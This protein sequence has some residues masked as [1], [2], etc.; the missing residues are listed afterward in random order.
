MKNIAIIAILAF[1]ALLVGFSFLSEKPEGTQIKQ[2]SSYNELQNFIKTNLET[3]SYFGGV[4]ATRSAIAE[5][6][7]AAQAPGAKSEDYSTTNI[8]VAGVDEAD[9]VKND[10]K[11]IYVVSGNSV[12]IL[13]AYPAEGAKIISTIDLNSAPSEIFVNGDKL[14]IFSQDYNYYIQPAVGMAEIA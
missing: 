1:I 12:V 14:V 8:Q 13:D 10:G 2:F 5:A 4:F 3:P 9:I 7:T 11:Y 6:G